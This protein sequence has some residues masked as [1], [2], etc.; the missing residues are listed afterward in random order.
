MALCC[1]DARIVASNM[2]Y[3]LDGEIGRQLASNNKRG[4]DAAR[5]KRS[6]RVN[7]NEEGKKNNM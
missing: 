1:N 7:E 2:A 4:R 6:D 3:S 5:R